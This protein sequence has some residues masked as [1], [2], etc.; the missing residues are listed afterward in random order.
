MEAVW[1]LVAW[2]VQAQCQIDSRPL[3][4]RVPASLTHHP[5][6]RIIKNNFWKYQPYA[7]YIWR[8]SSLAN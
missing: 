4:L 8:T 1:H 6:A 3:A 5:S 2:T 7:W